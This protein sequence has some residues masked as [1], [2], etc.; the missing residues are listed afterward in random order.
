MVPKREEE[1]AER[2]QETA[3]WQGEEEGPGGEGLGG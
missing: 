2:G 3:R 1:Q